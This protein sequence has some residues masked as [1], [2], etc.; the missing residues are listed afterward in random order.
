MCIVTSLLCNALL[1]QKGV[2][3]TCWLDC[4]VL[5]MYFV[6][7]ELSP[8]C[9]GMTE[10]T[11]TTRNYVQCRRLQRTLLLEQLAMRVSAA[12]PR[13]CESWMCGSLNSASTSSTW[14]REIPKQVF[15]QLLSG[16]SSIY[17]AKRLAAVNEGF[18]TNVR[19]EPTLCVEI[20]ITSRESRTTC[21]SHKLRHSISQSTK[22][23]IKQCWVSDPHGEKPKPVPILHEDD[24]KVTNLLAKEMC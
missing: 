23:D 22:H 24:R 8:S 5:Y 10:E 7:Q 9:T 20:F 3:S 2:D 1:G 14:L 4:W 13:L 12:K 16:T 11:W 18:T 17:T 19:T 21:R 6:P 15:A